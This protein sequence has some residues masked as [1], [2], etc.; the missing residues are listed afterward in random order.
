[1]GIDA[2]TDAQIV[3]TSLQAPAVFAQLFDR[4]AVVV[5]RYAR[6]RA[7][8][9]VADD[10]MAETFLVA[11]DRRHTYDLEYPDARPWLLGV[12]TRLLARYE[13]AEIRRWSAYGRVAARAPDLDEVGVDVDAIVGKLDAQSRSVELARQLACLH[14]RDRDVL[15]LFGLADL[16]YEQIAS[17]LDI[18][19]GT[20]RSRLNRARR[21]MQTGL[22]QPQ[23]VC[24][25]N[26]HVAV[27]Q[28]VSRERR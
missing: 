16:T 6:R 20:V 8:E 27:L 10:V 17:A 19:V 25:A 1:M 18:P 5:H 22:N 21:L 12:A 15:L 7:G 14:Q 13:R 9:V 28:E 26:P 4:H 3:A 23:P 2:E 11:F 24:A